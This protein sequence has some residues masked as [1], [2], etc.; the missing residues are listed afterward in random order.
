MDPVRDCDDLLHHF[1]HSRPILLGHPPHIE[2]EIFRK[3]GIAGSGKR[4]GHDVTGVICPH[5][6]LKIAVIALE[7][8]QHVQDHEATGY[9]YCWLIS[10]M[11]LSI[12]GLTEGF[13]A[14]DRVKSWSASI[15]FPCCNKTNPRFA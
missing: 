5:G 2:F 15:L 12:K 7:I 6:R 10:T 3:A 9:A 13:N 11:R 1:L 4:Y 8:R 14:M